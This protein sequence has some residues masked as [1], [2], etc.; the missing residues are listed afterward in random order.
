M[1]TDDRRGP[2]RVRRCFIGVLA[3]FRG[4]I[5]L[6]PAVPAQR[7]YR[8]SHRPRALRPG[9]PRPKQRLRRGD[10]ERAPRR[11]RR[12]HG[13]AAA[14]GLL[15]PGG[16]RGAGRRPRRCCSRC[17]PPRSWPRRSPGCTPVIPAASALGVAAGALP[18]DFEVAGVEPGR[19]GRTLQVGA[20]PAGR[21]AARR[22]SGPARRGPRLAGLSEHTRA[23]AQR[24]RVGGRRRAGGRMRGRH[25]HG[26]HVGA[27]AAG[28]PD[29]GLRRGRR[30]RR[31]G[32]HP[33]GLA[34][35]R[36]LRP[37]GGPA[38]GLRE[39]CR[40]RHA[41]GADQTIASD[42]PPSWPSG[43]WGSWRRSVPTR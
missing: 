35:P 9:R 32:A 42:D 28:P 26:G 2:A 3:P 16:T 34:R 5:G 17:A 22:G 38:G 4:G 30:D 27:R 31:Q 21:H 20:S 43:W 23:R 33:P 37:G 12:V 39:L 36:A 18:L 19:G 40:R 13:P 10:D 41:F 14:D 8:R 24:R 1:P 11:L 6:A 7:A 25:P 15:R 29:R